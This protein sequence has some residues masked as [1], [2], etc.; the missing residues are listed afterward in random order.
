MFL[1]D[2][3]KIVSFALFV[4]VSVLPVHVSGKRTI[5]LFREIR[6]PCSDGRD[7]SFRGPSIGQQQ[8]QLALEVGN[9]RPALRAQLCVQCV[10]KLVP[11]SSLERTSTAV[12]FTCGSTVKTFPIAVLSASSI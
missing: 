1:G 6:V 3:P 12:R 11:E 7:L 2:A 4:Q 8:S 10:R 9:M 5:Y